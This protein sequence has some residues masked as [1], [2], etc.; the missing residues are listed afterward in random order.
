MGIFKH[1]VQACEGRSRS[2]ANYLVWRHEIG[3]L[4]SLCVTMALN[5]TVP[6]VDI[7]QMWL[8]AATLTLCFVHS[9]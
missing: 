5:A 6:F 1:E 2:F 9:E 4:A 8:K 7:R 3:V